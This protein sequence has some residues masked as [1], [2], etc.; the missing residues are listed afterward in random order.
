MKDIIRIFNSIVKF[1]KFI[2]NIKIYEEFKRFISKL[3]WRNFVFRNRNEKTGKLSGEYLVPMKV[4][5]NL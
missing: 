1:S 4:M 5:V 2:L 3:V